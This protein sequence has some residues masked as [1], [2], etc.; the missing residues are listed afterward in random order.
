MRNRVPKVVETDQEKLLTEGLN[1]PTQPALVLKRKNRVPLMRP[2]VDSE[3]LEAAVHALQNEKLVLG[4]S[5]FKFEEEFARFCGTRFGISTGSGTAALQIALQSLGIGHGDEVLTTP[6][7]FFATSNAVI[8]A[9]AQP[10][11]A[12][13][14]DDAFNLD[15]KKVE[16]RLTA[17]TRS[18][19]PVHLYGTPARMSPLRE[20]A[21]KRNIPL[22]EDACQ[23]HGAEYHGKRV[24]SIGDAGCFS[25]YTS[26]NMTVCGDGGMITTDSEELAEAARSFRDCGRSTKYTMAR[27]G[28]TSRLNTVNAAIGRIQLKRLPE[29]NQKRQMIANLY[30]KEL[31]GL[32]GI[33]LPPEAPNGESAVYHLFVIRSTF[34]DRLLERLEA[35]GVEAGIH[36]PTPIHLQ[37][38]YR[39]KYNYKEGDFPVSE[40]LAQEV[41]SLPLY[42]EATEEDVLYV[43]RIIRDT[44]QTEAKLS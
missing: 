17:R 43:S 42:P 36:Y 10:T 38:P 7:S 25:F 16:R 37:G 4:E 21:E 40:K 34:R 20:I 28:Y 30:R 3:M 2:V 39:S 24:G 35:N 5:V 27:V 14:E 1:G 13:V 31:S 18:I 41:L 19:I 29:W 23:A 32:E 26:K 8:H 11:F 22:I 44:S 9:E 33:T 12:D 15:P 6:F